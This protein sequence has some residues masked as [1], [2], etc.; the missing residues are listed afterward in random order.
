[1]ANTVTYLVRH[2]IWF[3][4]IVRTTNKLP[5][6]LKAPS[7]VSLSAREG[8]RD[9]QNP[10]GRR[11][12]SFV[13]ARSR[14]SAL[15]NTRPH[16]QT[17]PLF[18][19]CRWIVMRPRALFAIIIIVIIIII[20]KRYVDGRS[21]RRE[22]GWK[23]DTTVS[24]CTLVWLYNRLGLA[25][26]DFPCFRLFSRWMDLKWIVTRANFNSFSISS[27]PCCTAAK[28]WMS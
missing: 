25:H 5:I 20:S 11:P 17:S 26:I 24:L 16:T 13:S 6:C 22:R 4:P 19:F 23:R 2:I 7:P 15:W 21:E 28:I 8:S 10:R 27:L 18:P 9:L 12:V 1:M 14:W 3:L